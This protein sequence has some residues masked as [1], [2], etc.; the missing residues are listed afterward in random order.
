[1]SQS[2]SNSNNNSSTSNV[3]VNATA[4]TTITT[5]NNNNR[6]DVYVGNLSMNTT[7]EQLL[8]VFSDV[9]SVKQ[10]KMMKDPETM[11][12]RGFAFV[13]Y[14]DPQA[15]LSA[16]RTMNDYELN[17]RKIRVTFSNPSHLESLAGKLGMD[18]PN[19]Q[20]QQQSKPG[21]GTLAV[22][23]ALKGMTKGELYDIVLS[24]KQISE[25]DPDE[26]RRILTG[27]PQLQEAILFAMSKLDMIKTPLAAASAAPVVTPALSEPVVVAVAPVHA[28]SLKGTDPRFVGTTTTTVT[29]A[30]IPTNPSAVPL[31]LRVDPRAR[32]ADPRARDPRAAVAAPLLPPPPAAGIGG[33]GGAASNSNW[34][35]A[36]VQQI[37]SLTPQQIAQLP[38][39][40]SASILAL[41]NQIMAGEAP[42]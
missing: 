15:A 29:T 28:P 20:A 23:E 1:M 5:T 19:I 41:R 33:G 34:D 11:N 36:L 9:G 31:P 14:Q 6:S 18:V 26:A 35:P 12:P 8:E 24:L 30:A 7:E 25:R 21:K 4:T 16:I 10:V 39:D 42:R 40:K 32:A 13:E 38:P 27:H 22:A 17:G 3:I 2:T 37:M